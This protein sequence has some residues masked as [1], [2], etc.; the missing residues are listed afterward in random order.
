[1]RPGNAGHRSWGQ[2][3]PFSLS[4][5][6]GAAQIADSRVWHERT[7]F[8]FNSLPHIFRRLPDIEIHINIGGYEYLGFVQR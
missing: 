7:C 3:Q 8:T 2:G 5:G 4:V 1:M 6:K